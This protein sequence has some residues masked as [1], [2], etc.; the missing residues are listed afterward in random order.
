MFASAY[1][2]LQRGQHR[3]GDAFRFKLQLDCVFRAERQLHVGEVVRLHERPQILHIHTRTPHRL[4]LELKCARVLLG[5][6]RE[7]GGE[8]K[9][10][11]TR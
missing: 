7:V 4:W 2:V 10:E 3:L 6:K 11:V 8:G 1:F 9:G 5:S